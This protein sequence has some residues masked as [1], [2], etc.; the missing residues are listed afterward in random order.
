MLVLLPVLIL[1]LGAFGIFILQRTRQGMGYSWLFA[2]GSTLLTWLYLLILHWFDIQ[3]LVIP[4]W[5]S[6]YNHESYLEFTIDSSSL[7]YA[8]SLVSLLFAVLLTDPARLSRH[9]STWTWGGLLAITSG[10]IL[11]I[12]AGNPLTLVL[13]WTAIDF[14]ELLFH[15][16]NSP[17]GGLDIQAVLS[18][19]SRILGSFVVIWAMILGQSGD[20]PLTFDSVTPEIGLYLL[21]ATGLRLGVIPLYIPYSQD[22]P[23]RRGLGTILRLIAPA[24]S[25]VMLAR[26]PNL[27]MP[28]N[29]AL[30]LS[31]F[32]ALAA[33]FGAGMWL[34]AKDEIIGRPYWMIAL[35][36]MAVA[37]VV[38]VQSSASIAWGVTLLLS[39]GVLFLYSAR[40]H[41]ILF[42]PLLGFLGVCGLPFSPAV[43]GW[44]GLVVFPFNILD[45]L[46]LIAHTLLILGYI[47]H[48]LHEAD[49]FNELDQWIKAIYPMGLIILI[50]SHWITSFGAGVDLFPDGVWWAGL[51]SLM[52]ALTSMY[53]FDRMKKTG[54]E[55]RWIEFISRGSG[56]LAVEIFSLGWFYKILWR[57]Y[58]IIQSLFAFI[59][60][61][62][63]GDGGVLWAL[64][65]LT[66]LYSVLRRGG[67]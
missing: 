62:L 59:S 32:T 61:I 17:K 65:L 67:I 42:I 37:C 44:K 31:A 19:S 5:F 51:V 47:R 40:Q 38:R 6:V 27:V 3:P 34:S 66:L 54:A 28:V 20:V 43:S 2:A 11:A 30:V 46:F 57:L 22:V 1:V 16:G 26:L 25:L 48:M 4:G 63:E 7:P 56:R 18:F 33:L 50:I 14:M 35:A 10:G 21:L 36:G 29:W 52:S 39:G 45:L 49:S 41:R 13:A 64:L 58:G 15:L 12:L 23:L 24:S 53:L 9:Y 55:Y 60:K 8:F